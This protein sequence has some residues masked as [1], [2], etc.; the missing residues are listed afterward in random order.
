M[1]VIGDKD[2]IR[3]LLNGLRGSVATA[4]RR[5]PFLVYSEVQDS[6][7]GT[8][9]PRQL[10]IRCGPEVAKPREPVALTFRAGS[11]PGR[12]RGGFIQEEQLGVMAT[13]TTFTATTWTNTRLMPRP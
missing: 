9:R 1:L 4:D 3:H 8:G 6:R 13:F 5:S 10:G 2:A 11:M 12:Q 7:R